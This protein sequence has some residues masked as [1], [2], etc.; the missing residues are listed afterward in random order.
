MLGSKKKTFSEACERNKAPILEVLSKYT[1]DKLD[2]L[3]I[4][5]GN[6]QHACFFAEN[7][8]N[9]YWHTSDRRENHSEI[10]A[11]IKE[12]KLSNLKY[13]L[14]FEIGKDAFPKQSF[15]IVF[16]ANTFHIMS[17]KKVKTLMRLLDKGLKK[18]NVSVLIYGPFNYHGKFTSESNENFDKLL[19]SRD[20]SSGIRSFEDVSSNML[21]NNFFLLEDIEM[22]ANNRLLV[23]SR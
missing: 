23:F 13:P 17:W 6:G 16:T 1:K 20:P 7:L 10:Q 14:E 2:L 22:P 12:K 15:D 3:E 8:P 21:K 9:I 19:K 11:W 4:G 18:K 5:S